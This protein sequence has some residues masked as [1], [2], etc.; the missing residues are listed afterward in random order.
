MGGCREAA[1]AA[2]S[3]MDSHPERIRELR[4]GTCASDV[5]V[6]HLAEAEGGCG[7]SRVEGELPAGRRARLRLLLCWRL[8]SWRWGVVRGRAGLSRGV[9]RLADAG[10][11]GERIGGGRPRVGRAV[12][13]GPAKSA[14]MPLVRAN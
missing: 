4:G 7:R 12:A 3:P 13:G 10:D 9:N 1:E 2:I 8:F 5:H 14:L 11:E 6:D